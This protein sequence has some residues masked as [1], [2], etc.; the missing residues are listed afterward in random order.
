MWGIG[1]RFGIS[2]LYPCGE[3]KRT[4]RPGRGS[5]PAVY[6]P[7]VRSVP[8]K[9][10]R[11]GWGSRPGRW[12]VMGGS[13]GTGHVHRQVA[14]ARGVPVVVALQVRVP[15]VVAAVAGVPHAAAPVGVITA[16]VVVAAGG[17]G[18]VRPG[19]GGGGAVGAVG[20]RL[21]A[22]HGEAGEGDGGA[23]EHLLKHRTT[24]RGGCSLEVH[25]GTGVAVSLFSSPA[26]RSA[27]G[28]SSEG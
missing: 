17:A 18:A 12:L 5:S 28:T 27:L 4:E 26:S 6:I 10:T 21:G 19:V 3:C 23:E 1:S 11:P 24:P 7:R 2:T 14:G 20:L 16:G 9:R 15:V 22:G 13:E 25:G 8:E